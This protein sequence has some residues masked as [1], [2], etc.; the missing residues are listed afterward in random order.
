MGQKNKGFS[1][2]LT[3][4]GHKQKKS[5]L[6]LLLMLV[7]LYGFI[8]LLHQQLATNTNWYPE[9]ISTRLNEPQSPSLILRL[10]EQCKEQ[11]STRTLLSGQVYIQCGKFPVFD[12]K[13]WLAEPEKAGY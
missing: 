9:W 1:V 2:S 6:S 8:I 10:G 5:L 4:F 11:L 13:A 7:I 12:M 3:L